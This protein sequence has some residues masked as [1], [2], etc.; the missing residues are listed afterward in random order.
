MNDYHTIEQIYSQPLEDLI[1]QA[2]LAKKTFGKNDLQF[3]QLLNIKSGGCS[4]DCKYC[5]QSAHYRTSIEK[6]SLLDEET[7]FEAGK[8]AKEN[9][10]TRFCLGAAWKGL[11]HEELKTKLICKIISKI[12]S[13]GLEL[14]LSLGFLTEKAALMLKESGLSVYNHNLNTG[15]NYY[16]KIATTHSF[17]ERLQT[18]EIVQKVGL[19]LCSGGI[20]GMGESLKDRLEM[21]YYLKT[22]PEPPESVPINVYMPIKGTPLYAYQSNFSYIDLVRIIATARILFPTSWIRLAAGR[23]LLDESIQ[24]L[25]YIAG[26]NSIFIGEKLLTQNNVQLET[27]LAWLKRLNLQKEGYTRLYS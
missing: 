4:E 5:A 12:S 1:Q 23:K 6:S 3:C 11:S 16:P 19:K 2:L 18:I 22:L 14:C 15:P 24:T 13:L 21:L 17:Q 26:V 27:D 20:I 25:C 7:I 8:K 9:G 10:A